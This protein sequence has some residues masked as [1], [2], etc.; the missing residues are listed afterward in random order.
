[1]SHLGAD[2]RNIPVGV[3]P[4]NTRETTL[5]P[6][7]ASEAFLDRVRALFSSAPTDEIAPVSEDVAQE[8]ISTAI[9]HTDDVPRVLATACGT[10]RGECCTAGGTHAFLRPDSVPRIRAQH[11]ELSIDVLVERYASHLP[12]RHYRGSCVYHAATGCALPRDLRSNLCN[13]YVCGGITQLA[14]A[15]AASD[16]TTV[17][18]AAADSAHLR[19]MARVDTDGVVPISLTLSAAA[20]RPSSR[21]RP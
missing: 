20:Q 18:I 19:R 8:M 2:A 9:A 5:L 14:N 13:R 1:M 12:E 10:C 21:T 16:G 11:A 7:D 15:L 4:A 3:V 17:F 6:E